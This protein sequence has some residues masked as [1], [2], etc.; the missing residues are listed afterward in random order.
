MHTYGCAFGCVMYLQGVSPRQTWVLLV[1]TVAEIRKCPPL[2]T[3][4]MDHFAAEG[5]IGIKSRA[6]TSAIHS[7]VYKNCKPLRPIVRLRKDL[8]KHPPRM[9][10]IRILHKLNPPFGYHSQFSGSSQRHYQLYRSS[11]M[12]SA[13]LR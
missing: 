1:S 8:R 5:A 7:V 3:T 12:S 13:G 9:C 11:P 2:C 4:M 6:H 10:Q